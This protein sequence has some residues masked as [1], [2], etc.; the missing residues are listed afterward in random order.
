[1]VKGLNLR[2]QI[3]LQVFSDYAMIGIEFTGIRRMRFGYP[4]CYEFTH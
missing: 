2:F 1:M 3:C 4:K